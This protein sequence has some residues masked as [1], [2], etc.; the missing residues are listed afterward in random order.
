MRL[1][2]L[3]V[4]VTLAS[5]ARS[6]PQP[7]I[8]ISFDHDLDGVTAAGPLVGTPVGKPVLAPGKTGQALKSGP[9]TGY[10]DYP[11]ALL[12][13]D[14]GTVEMWVQ[15]LDW[16]PSEEFFHAFF[17]TRGE[18]SLYLYKYYQGS[19][20]LMLTCPHLKGPY[21]DNRAGLDWKPG[22]WHHIAGTWSRHGVR[23]YVDG[24]P[25]TAMPTVGVLPRTLGDT[26]RIGDHPWHIERTTSSL[27]DEVR[28]YDRALS[29]AHLAAHAQ[30]NLDFVAPL[31]AADAQMTTELDP[32]RHELVVTLTTGGADVPDE[33]LRARVGIVAKGQ[34]LDNVPEREVVAGDVRVVLPVDVTKPAQLEVV[35]QMLQQGQQAF[36]LRRPLDVPDMTAWK[37]NTLGLEDRVLPPWTP[38][39]V[40]GGIVSVWD[41]DYDFSRCTDLV[42]QI[43]SGGNPLLAGPVRLRTDDEVHMVLPVDVTVNAAGTRATVARGPDA[44]PRVRTTIE[45]DGLAWFEMTGMPQGPLE[46]LTLDI[47]LRREIAMY[48]HR[49]GA[50]WDTSKV[51]GRL[52]EGQGVIDQDTFIPYYWLGNNDRGLFWF[53]ESDEMWPNGQSP[54]AVQVLR[55]G[56]AVTLRLNI[57]AKGQTLPDHWKLSF[58]LQATPVKPLPRDW[59]TWRLQPGHHANTSII[60]PTPAPDSLKYYG[61]PEAAN[62]SLFAERVQKLHEQGVRAVP[63][64]CLSYLSTACPEW[65]FFGKLWAMGPVDRSASD[66]AQYGA[67]FA[68]VSPLGK[69][70]ADFIVWKIKA[71]IDQYGVDG[72][73]HDNTHPYGSRALDAGCGYRRDGKVYPTY[74]IMGYRDLYRRMYAVLKSYPR[75]TFSMA[76]MSGKMTIPV[77]AYV[78]AILDGEHFRGRVQ[79][80]YLD[81]MGMDT[82]RAEYMG[83]QWGVMPFFLPQR[84][85]G[86]T[87]VELTRGLM[88]LLML[89]DSAVW[90]LHVDTAVA[91]E[92]LAALDDFGY[93][94]AEFI[95]YFDNPAPAM[96]AMKDVYVSAYRQGGRTLLIVG[97]VGREDRQGAVTL[98]AARFGGTLPARAQ[99]WPDRTPLAMINGTLNVSV[100]GLGYRLVVVE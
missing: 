57:L 44:W 20:L 18:G 90:N 74:P 64:L 70:F 42:K 36:E 23:V 34:A 50:D 46:S 77:L 60:W 43:T 12:K 16:G 54:D 67:G 38:V 79:G 11:A 30:G 40:A 100:P 91:N 31:N 55:E 62:P 21:A 19:S 49:Y 89:H 13:R 15:P 33:Q 24:K 10:V 22:E 87:Q 61:Y 72:L 99:D 58:G 26:F 3:L 5:L 17:D 14:S 45:Y 56:N 35:A 93:V 85:A 27:I 75:E 4:G 29:P 98:N 2:I 7:V 9:P 82:F 39:R 69:D 94:Q 51:T 96:T 63:Y 84:S 95:G 97:N 81:V 53:C 52:P 78:D 8:T 37:G 48:R 83:R 73:Y 86:R 68:Q 80:S 88:A 32:I 1:L 6:Q 41:R 28:I 66:V 47:P 25:G 76:H 71:F 92:A 59:R 65:P